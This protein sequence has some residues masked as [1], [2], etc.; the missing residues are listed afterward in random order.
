MNRPAAIG[1]TAVDA[2]KQ[3]DDL[4]SYAERLHDTIQKE[5]QATH[6]RQFTSY[7]AVGMSAATLVILGLLTWLDRSFDKSPIVLTAFSVAMAVLAGAGVA[8]RVLPFPKLDV[9]KRILGETIEMISALIRHLEEERVSPVDR[10]L[11]SLRLRRLR[12]SWG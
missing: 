8:I 12:L 11:L 2:L 1:T 7:F 10:K 6:W 5:H 4:I 3:L 9:E